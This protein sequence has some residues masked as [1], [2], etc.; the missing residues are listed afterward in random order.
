MTNSNGLLDNIR[1]K[2]KK[3]SPVVR[4]KIV[5]E[6]GVARGTS[7]PGFPKPDLY[8]LIHLLLLFGRTESHANTSLIKHGLKAKFLTFLAVTTVGSD[9]H[10]SRGVLQARAITFSFPRDAK[11]QSPHQP[12]ILSS[13]VDTSIDLPYSGSLRRYLI[14]L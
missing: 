8:L 6:R 9:R 12:I 10:F 2:C 3:R 4:R 5:P 1:A 11:Y 7:A 13:L 14:F